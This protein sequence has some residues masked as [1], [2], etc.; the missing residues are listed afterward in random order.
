MKVCMTLLP[1]LHQD[2]DE[3]PENIPH[4]IQVLRLKGTVAQDFQLQVFS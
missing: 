3:D 4:C 1:L 2:W